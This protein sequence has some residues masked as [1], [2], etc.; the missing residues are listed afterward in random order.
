V[1]A[2]E[3]EQK[4]AIRWWFPEI[5]LGAGI[6]QIAQ[7]PF[8]DLVS[9]VS[10]AIALPLLDRQQPERS[11]ADAQAQLARSQQSLLLARAAVDLRSVSKWPAPK[12]RGSFSRSSRLTIRVLV[13]SPC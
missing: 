8:D 6:K 10:T 12:S 7:G 5:A 13:S 4:A 3:L 9:L 1:A 2:A 11:R